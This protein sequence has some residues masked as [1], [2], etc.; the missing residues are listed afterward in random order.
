MSPISPSPSP[1]ASPPSETHPLASPVT[2]PPPLLPP[3]PRLSLLTRLIQSQ[4]KSTVL[5]PG[6]SPL[7]PSPSPELYFLPRLSPDSQESHH[8]PK[9]LPLVPQETAEHTPPS[10]IPYHGRVEDLLLF[11][12]LIPYLVPYSGPRTAPLDTFG[13]LFPSNAIPIDLNH[14]SLPKT[15]GTELEAR[16]VVLRLRVPTVSRNSLMAS[17][18]SFFK[19]RKGSHSDEVEERSLR[20]RSS[21][22]DLKMLFR[23]KPE[24]ISINTRVSNS[25]NNGLSYGA[26][27][28]NLPISPSLAR[29]KSLAVNLYTVPNQPEPLLPFSKRYSKMSESLG[30]GA[31]GL[32]RIVKRVSDKRIFAVK[33]FRQRFAN[34]SKKDYKKKI[35]LEFCIGSALKNTNVIETIEI[36]YEHDKIYQVMEYCEYDLFAIVM[37]GKMLPKEVDCCFKQILKGIRYLHSMGLAHR[38]LK[39]DNCC[40]TENGIVKVIDFGLSVVFAYPFS[41]K[42]VEASGI[43]GLDPYL[44]PEVVVFQKYDP[45]PVDIWLAAIVYLCMTLRKFPWK[46][47]KILD[48]SF[49]LFATRGDGLELLNSMLKRVRLELSEEPE[50]DRKTPLTTPEI[51]REEEKKPE[52]DVAK[53]DVNKPLPPVDKGKKLTGEDRLLHALPEYSRPLIR[54]MVQLA[55]ACRCT[56]EEI[57]EDPWL[58]SIDECYE[59]DCDG[60]KKLYRGESHRHTSVDQSEAHIAYLEKKKKHK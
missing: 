23:R 55:P 17:L 36:C 18:T 21:K 19:Q 25:S 51:S 43:V 33:E 20:H 37:S 45:R 40:I 47:P 52:A 30:A 22:H 56:I 50:L 5:Q 9:N 46:V 44:A 35:T 53:V 57:F 58:D 29:S 15:D 14:I 4:K 41:N 42:I 13:L 8:A 28:T 24:A 7:V 12:A 27:F 16:F 3:S 38:D 59:D 48:Q 11:S 31:G 6:P 49:K 1:L 2:L 60:D 32:V 39:L 26:L 54:K 10:Y 34:E